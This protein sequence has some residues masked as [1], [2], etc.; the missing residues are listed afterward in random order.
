MQ[1]TLH[2]ADHESFRDVAR[3]FVDRELLAH[4][5]EHR[6]LRP[7]P[8]EVWLRAGEQ[9]LLGLCIPEEYGGAGVADYRYNAVL[10]EELTRAGLGY[11]G[12]IGVHVHVIAPYMVKPTTQPQR[13]R[14]LPKVAS[15]ELV[16]GIAMTEPSGG[17]DLSAIRSRAE[18]TDRGW[19]FNGSKICITNGLAADLLLV[20]ARTSPAGRGGRGL[21]LFGV[22]THAPGF[23]RGQNLAKVGSTRPTAE[24][25][26]DD[27]EL[28]DDD[29]VGEV[30]VGFAILMEHLPQE[31][32][33]SAVCNVTHAREILRSTLDYVRT[34]TAFGRSIADF[35]DTR[36]GLADLWGDV[37]IAQAYV[38]ACVAAHVAGQLDWVD[39]AVAKLKSSNVQ[40]MVVDACVQMF[41]G[42]GYIGRRGGRAGLARTLGSPGSGRGPARSCARSSAAPSCQGS[43]MP[44]SPTVAVSDVTLVACHSA[45]LVVYRPNGRSVSFN[46]SGEVRAMTEQAESPVGVDP[47]ALAVYLGQHL[48]APLAGE[49]E[50]RLVAGGRSNL[51]YLLTDSVTTWVLRRPPIGHVLATAHDMSRE[52]RVLS[53]LQASPV[54]VPRPVVL[55]PKEVLGAPCYL[56]EFVDGMVYRTA[57]Q[58]AL[59]QPESC[60]ALADDLVDVL[61]A[62]HQL[63]PAQ[64]GLSEFGRP[65]NYLER[66]LARWK[67]QLAASK[68]RELPELHALGERLASLLPE[69]RGTD[70]IVHGDYRLDNVIAH[71]TSATVAAVLDWEM[72]T[73]G[74]SLVDLGS[75]IL[76]WDGIAGLD[77]VVA[78]VPGEVPGFPS[79]TRLIERYAERTGADLA[80]LHWYI[81]FSFYKMAAIFEGIHF[82]HVN[83]WTVGE[84]FERLG[85][86]VPDLVERGHAELALTA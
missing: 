11:A 50:A 26:F 40:S 54:P 15:G 18:R 16:T 43:P 25:F 80:S 2:L 4:R 48:E 31:R 78:A 72:A 34:R 13:D 21:T 33:A 76:W 39:A 61:A 53:A 29:V 8:R 38:D 82:R 71:S 84:G 64:V 83:G 7:I 9:G 45:A 27:L 81:A 19:L 14:W 67:K 36:F 85:G 32:L 3:T 46:V 47:R 55:V 62:L 30:D 42:Y 66:Q 56:M 12:A 44:E 60:A 5:D 65:A 68:S 37:E 57:E 22:P 73:L 51:T 24:L 70:S 58:L 74:D 20:V 77:H 6:A 49:L 17:S 75:L 69:C 41:G 1:R 79:R 86:Q 59:L 10:D 63:D 35:Q 28:T 52:Y 23:R